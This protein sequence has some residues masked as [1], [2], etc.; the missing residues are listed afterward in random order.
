MVFSVIVHLQQS[1]YWLL[2]V[3]SSKTFVCFFLT[4]P[5]QLD[6]TYLDQMLVDPFGEGFFLYPVPFIWKK[7]Q[8]G[9][10]MIFHYPHRYYT[11]QGKGRDMFSHFLSLTP[12]RHH[13]DKL[14]S[15]HLYYCNN[16]APAIVLS[17]VLR[18]HW[19]QVE[20]VSIRPSLSTD[21]TS[22]T[23]VCR[24]PYHV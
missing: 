4:Y 17:K 1:L 18:V 19:E 20:V 24:Y 15:T 23:V 8:K 12:P 9:H 6:D 13:Y 22:H 16:S 7:T 10:L 14:I 3:N 11:K 2:E 21:A 5:S